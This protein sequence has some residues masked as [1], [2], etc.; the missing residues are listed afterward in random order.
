MAR[1]TRQRAA[2]ARALEEAGGFRSAQSLYDEMRGRGDKVGLTTVYRNLQALADSGEVDV[3]RA[4][5]GEAIYRR[6][7]TDDHHHHLVCTSCGTSV[8]IESEAV[9]AWA[10]HAAQRH[11]FTRVEHTAEVFGLCS[12]CAG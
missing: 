6:C 11:G 5:D 8:E 12:G 4:A 1:P 2:I 7:S 10:E 3:L 9:E